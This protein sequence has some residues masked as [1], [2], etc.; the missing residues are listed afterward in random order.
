MLG[1]NDVKDRYGVNAVE[2]GY[3]LDEIMIRLKLSL[4]HI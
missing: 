1:T 3:G 2:I 4:I